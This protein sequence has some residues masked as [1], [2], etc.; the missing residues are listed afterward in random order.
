MFVFV[1]MIAGVC[2]VFMIAGVCI[3]FMIAG[4]CIVFMTGS[5][6]ESA[7][8]PTFHCVLSVWRAWNKGEPCWVSGISCELLI[9]L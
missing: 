3:V 6:R 1:F 7:A 9:L 8:V 5:C 4:V 2:I